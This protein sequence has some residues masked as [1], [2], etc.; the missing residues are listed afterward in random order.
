[1]S[2]GL[3]PPPSARETLAARREVLAPRERLE[4]LCDPGSLDL[5][6]GGVRSRAMGPGAAAGDGVVAGA[7][8][9]DGRAVFCFAQD[10]S[11]AGGSLGLAQA[12]TIVQL[13]ELA[14]RARAPVVGFIESGGARLQEGVDALAGYGRIFRQHVRLSGVVPQIS[15]VCGPSAGGGCYAPALTD[16]VV[17]TERASMFLT[18]PSVVRQVTG[19]SVSAHELGGPGVHAANGVCHAVVP[20][21]AAA[22]E[23]ARAL[24]GHLHGERRPA[25]ATDD[26]D[27]SSIVPDAQRAVYD[28]REVARALTDG[29]LLEVSP[30]YARNI[31]CGFARVR[32]RS[33]GIVANQPRRLGGV[34]DA[35]ASQKAAR[36]VRT[37]NTF[38][39]PLLVLVDTPG[40]LPGVRQERD[41]VIRHG[42]K[43]LYAFAE[44][45]VPR[46]SVL[47]RKAFGGAAIAMNSKQLGADYVFAWP[48]AE[49]GVMGAAQAVEIVNR[50]EIE[51]A[52]DRGTERALLAATYAD[53]HL[54]A[55]G[56]AA[57]GFVDEVIEPRETRSRVETALASLE[58]TRADA[59]ARGNI[60]L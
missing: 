28:V 34:I 44:C 11:F 24:L 57:A 8:R 13:H 23:L 48:G 6:R 30:R 7:G 18:G 40:F 56:A 43:L 37:C 4:R 2:L 29:E 46:V 35:A 22:A 12:D 38:G 52:T 5:I 36:F 31:V 27:P 58:T 32:G 15:V 42:A 60:P 47:L 19:E 14:A 59:P 55:A 53:K 9:I 51:R 3:R 1:M 26:V 50:R 21:D 45:T 17:M 33:V 10:A 41:G 25:P 20:D 49:I 54:R 39:V 16:F